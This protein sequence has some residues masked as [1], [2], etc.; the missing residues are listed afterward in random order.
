MELAGAPLIAIDPSLPLHN[1]YGLHTSIQKYG[2]AYYRV[3]YE[4]PDGRFKVLIPK[5]FMK[6]KVVPREG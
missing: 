1:I 6:T 2:S 5:K 4:S 3:G